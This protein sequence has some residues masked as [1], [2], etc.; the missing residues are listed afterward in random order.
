MARRPVEI[1]YELLQSGE[2]ISDLLQ[3][4]FGPNGLGIVTVSGVPGFA[5]ARGRLLPL[6]AAL[7]GL[8]A[9]EKAALEDAGSNYNVGWSH[10]KEALE[11]GRLDL[12]KGSF[13][14]NPCR[15]TYDDREASDVQKYRDYYTDNRWPRESLPEL[16]PALKGLGRLMVSVGL[17]LAD[18]CTDYVSRQLR[19]AALAGP[20][21][22]GLEAALAAL[23]VGEGRPGGGGGGAGGG[24]KADQ[25]RRAGAAGGGGGCPDF[26]AALRDSACHRAR[27]LHYFPPSGGGGEGDWCGWHFDHGALTALTSALYLDAS[28][29]PCANP[30]PAGGLYIRDRAGGVVQAAIPPGHVAFQ[31]GQAMAIQ[32]GGLL[33]ATPHFVRAARPELGAGVSRN[34][35]AVFLQPDASFVMAPPRPPPGRAGAG[36]GLGAAAAAALPLKLTER[37]ASGWRDGQTFGAFAA[38]VMGRY[39]DTARRLAR[40]AADGAAGGGGRR[41]TVVLHVEAE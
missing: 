31:M 20:P 11:G 2:D 16:E 25:Q 28:G 8:P 26:G 19:A 5:A 27:L 38:A 30:D 10:G 4:G 15:D 40:E 35:F 34:T 13:Y 36:L 41:P 12:L 1:T 14:A 37:E 29:A 22:P 24:E 33:H 7:A 32:S 9:A 3:E 21:P 17:L 23:D 39:Y 18:R 6:A